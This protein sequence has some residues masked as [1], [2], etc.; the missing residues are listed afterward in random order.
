MPF[1]ALFAGKDALE[2][3]LAMV[4]DLYKKNYIHLQFSSVRRSV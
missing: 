3:Y 4:F 1:V 2:S